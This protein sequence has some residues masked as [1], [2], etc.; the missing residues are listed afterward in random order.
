MALWRSLGE[1]IG[2]GGEPVEPSRS[3]NAG[4][5]QIHKAR[6]EKQSPRCNPGRSCC[7]CRRRD[8]QTK[9][10]GA[11]LLKHETLFLVAANAVSAHSLR[12]QLQPLLRWH[13]VLTNAAFG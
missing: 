9:Q 8:V 10:L 7:G 5:D 13:V 6:T 2:T 3:G 1:P 4:E 12:Q 11:M